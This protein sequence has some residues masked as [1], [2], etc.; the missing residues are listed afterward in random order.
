M[1][2]VGESNRSRP[3]S[4]HKDLV[5]HRVPE[6]QDR[7]AAARV[8]L[9]G[10]A[11][12]AA[13][14]VA[15]PQWYI[16]RPALQR[17]ADIDLETLFADCLERMDVEG[18]AALERTCAAHP[19]H[20][21][22]LRQM[23]A[24]L[25]RMGPPARPP[26]LG[27]GERVGGF[28]ILRELGSGGMGVVY[29]AVEES[30]GREVALKLLHP[31]LARSEAHRQRFLREARALARLEHKALVAVHAH[32]EHEGRLFLAMQLVRGQ[33]LAELVAAA[34]QPLPVAQVLRW[35]KDLAE[36]LACAHAAGVVHRDVK[37]HNVVVRADGS[38]VLIDFGLARD[39][40]E[41]SVTLAG[42]FQGSPLYAAPEQVRGEAAIGPA[43]DIYGLGITLYEALSGRAPFVA[44]TTEN[45]FVQVLIGVPERLRRRRREI[46]R[47]VETVV[48]KAI[49][50]AVAD[51][52]ASAAEF[53]D[54]L[55]ALLELR[56]VRAAPPSWPARFL[57]WVRRNKALAA[58][59]TAALA[60]LLVLPIAAE[61]STRREAGRALDQAGAGI[62]EYRT[63]RRD[64]SLSERRLAELRLHRLRRF[65]TPAEEAEAEQAEAKV[66]Q[67][68][69][70]REELAVEIL[71][72]IARAER[73]HPGRHGVHELELE[74]TLEQWREAENLCGEARSGAARAEARALAEFRR[75][76]VLQ[77]DRTGDHAS[78]LRG[79]GE[80]RLQ[81]APPAAEVHL[82]RYESTA[83]FQPGVTPRLVPVPWRARGDELPLSPGALALRV[84][85]GADPVGADTVILTLQG[86]PIADAAAARALAER[87]GIVAEVWQEGARR[88]LVLPA[89]LS[90][91][92]TGAAL[93]VGALSRLEGPH[94]SRRLPRGDYLLLARQPGLGTIRHFAPIEADKVRDVRLELAAAELAPPDFVPVAVEHGS[95]RF[96]HVWL[97]DH[98][99]TIADYLGFLNDPETRKELVAA[100]RLIRVPR[101]AQDTGGSGYLVRL[102]DGSL[103]LPPSWQPGFP[104]LGISWRDAR[105]YCQWYDRRQRQAG[106]VLT[107]DLP[108]VRELEEASRSPG[109]Y[110]Y[111][112]HFRPKWVKSNWSRERAMVEPVLT[113]PFDETPS[114]LFD[115]AGSV[116]EMTTR[117]FGSETS[118]E[119]VALGGSWAIADP[120]WFRTNYW[121]GVGEE[122]P[123]DIAGFRLVAHRR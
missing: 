49:A 74:F 7:V 5:A 37:P 108:E 44:G 1:A 24:A 71:G 39:F 15:A 21:D 115:L 94:A 69:R 12:I 111:G 17:M 61:L 70:R 10:S 114:G 11:I 83:R 101:S 93:L 82:F 25:Q 113:F 35:G 109:F 51:R 103:G 45:V 43:A 16:S 72:E 63:L 95:S 62:A 90:T 73:L 3:C 121:S 122:V 91:R 36:A 13:R 117:V 105:S 41:P 18:E 20:A 77:L 8:F 112:D 52:Y 99:V 60:A 27:Q 56:P 58:T 84:V 92:A 97:Q 54:D 34:G 14:A 118:G 98:E 55:G 29:L 26:V 42:S 85:R 87:G 64:H 40:L 106:S 53:A 30:L 102:A 75:A 88:E 76:R 59:S 119:R 100:P 116:C 120:D 104:V 48:H 86:A 50:V 66:A 107:F 31:E 67:S 19:Q 123:T 4:G 2:L 46:T 65:L 79:E 110:V 28:R 68:R 22:R 9:E 96:E 32:G 80:L 38:A 47:D 57:R 6:G 89:G 78:E 81:V 33:T 23:W